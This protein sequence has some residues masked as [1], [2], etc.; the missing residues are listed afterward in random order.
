M[1]VAQFVVQLRQLILEYPVA[2]GYE[3]RVS[4][5][6]QTAPVVTVHANQGIV[7]IDTETEEVANE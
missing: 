6:H 3:I 2:S 5:C 7:L 4:T 1:T